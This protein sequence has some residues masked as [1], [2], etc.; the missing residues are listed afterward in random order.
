MDAASD[1]LRLGDYQLKQLLAEGPLTRTWLAE[2]LTVRRDVLI[3][4]LRDE[5]LQARADF[6]ADVRAKA[7]ADHP[8]I[9]SVYE[10]VADQRGCFF[11]RERLPGITLGDHLREGGTVPPARLA[12]ALRRTAEANLYLEQRGLASAPLGVD[13]IHLGE[14]GVVRL[15]NLVIAGERSPEQSCRDIVTLGASL[16]PLVPSDRPGATRLL[17]LLGWMRGEGLGEPLDWAQVHHYARL[18][19]GQLAETAHGSI[20]GLLYGRR[21]W[22]LRWVIAGGLLVVAAA[23]SGVFLLRAPKPEKPAAKPPES[24]TIYI[25][26]GDYPTPDGLQTTLPSFRLATHEVTIGQYA[27]FLETLAMLAR[28]G[29]GKVFDDES[30]PAEKADHEPADWPNLYAA[31]KTNGLWQDRPVT[32][33]SP[34]VG[35]DWWDAAAY[36][37]WKQGRLPTQEEWFAALSRKFDDPASLKPSNWL[38]VTADTPD[39]TPSGLTGMAGSVAEWTSSLAINPA[40][41]LGRKLWVIAGGSYLRPANGALAR[42]W[43]PSRAVRRP[44]LGFR[45]ATPAE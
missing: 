45:L 1:D 12:Q 2:Q 4:Q 24:E 18:V 8:L 44:D 43:T 35:V 29:R 38:P 25:P 34:V 14:Q 40:N 42:E 15:A 32:L 19:E 36:C 20:T 37:E 41:P 9:G 3:D 5:Q 27:E 28:E 16:L 39:R 10:A 21:G 31:A 11:A 6:L 26:G 30:Q 13:A 33:D 22:R 23:G 7:S 17:T